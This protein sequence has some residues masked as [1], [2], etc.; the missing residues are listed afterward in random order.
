MQSYK[1]DSSFFDFVSVSSGASSLTFLKQLD[2]GFFPQSVLDV[3]CGPGVWLNAWKVLGVKEVIGLDGNYVD[4]TSLL[5]DPSEFIACDIS[6]QIKLGKSFDLVQCLEVGEH[7][8]NEKANIL[9]KNLTNHSNIILFSSATPGQGGEHHINE[10]PLEYWAAKFKVEGY[11][12]FDYPRLVTKHIKSI[13]PWY[14]YNTLLFANSNGKSLLSQSVSQTAI[15]DIQHIP[16]YSPILWRLRCNFISIL[17]YFL[18]NSLARLKHRFV[19][20][21]ISKS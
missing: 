16:Q 10:R 5:I 12:A 11:D 8:S 14:R 15:Q 21:L 7:I 19:C 13:E 20:M 2:L 4:K 9:L 17:P 6:S 3:G 18:V 1:Y